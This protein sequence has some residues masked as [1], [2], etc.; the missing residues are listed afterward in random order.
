M[1]ATTHSAPFI[2]MCNQITL[3]LIKLRRPALLLALCLFCS[4]RPCAALAGLEE[5]V[6]AY[7][8]SDYA[9]ALREFKLLASQGHAG[10]Q[11][12]L[13]VMYGN[14]QGTVKDYKEAMK[15]FELAAQQGDVGA[16]T[17][18]AL[19]YKNGQGKA[20]DFS[21]AL[22]W[23][24][25]AASQGDALGQTGLAVMFE[26]GQ[27]VAKNLQE[28]LFWYQRA[29]D[30]GSALAQYN[31]GLI[32]AKGQG[33]KPNP[34]LAYALWSVSAAGDPSHENPAN[35]HRMELAESFPPKVLE[36]AQ[37]LAAELDKPGNLLKGLNAFLK[38]PAAAE[39]TK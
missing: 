30:Q 39:K 14:G 22:Y 27:G 6:A 23:Y 37:R 10:A 31:L 35:A 9:T 17:N 25:L 38:N 36:A 20:Q 28:A 32:Y 1:T 4:L 2:S 21:Q 12:N 26:R 29:A 15:W 16:Q 33:V 13:G 7:N 19:M 3:G 5:G 24:R 8:R 18:L 34:V 11:A